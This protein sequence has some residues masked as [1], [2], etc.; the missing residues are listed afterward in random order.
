MRRPDRSSGLR[1]AGRRVWWV[2]CAGLASCV[3][4]APGIDLPARLLPLDWPAR[5]Q[6]LRQWDE[7]SLRA[8]VS[9]ARDDEL[10]TARVGWRQRADRS[11]LKLTSPLGMG[12]MELVFDPRADFE[13]QAPAATALAEALGGALP[14]R[15]LRFWLLGI[16]DPEISIDALNFPTPAQALPSLLRQG[17]WEVSYRRYAPVP[18]TRLILPSR[19][20]LRRDTLEVRIFIES[21]GRTL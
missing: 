17:G 1:S 15:S 12:G 21:W 13:G 14:V 10:L 11:E 5:M 6:Q 16:P 20:D 2:L 4:F 7:F 9:V 8:R 19:I 18:E 3:S